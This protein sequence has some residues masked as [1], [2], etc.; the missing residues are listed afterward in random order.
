MQLRVRFTLWFALA[1]LVPIAVAAVVTRYVVARSYRQEHE[2]T[3]LATEQAVRGA[4]EE[5][6]K[7]VEGPIA[8]H[9]LGSKDH[10]VVGGILRELVKNGGELDDAALRR[11]KEIS[12][13]AMRGFSLDVLLVTGPGG[14]VLAA[15]HYRALTGEDGFN[16]VEQRARRSGGAPFYVWEKVMPASKPESVLVVASARFVN[17]GAMRVAVEVGRRVDGSLVEA[18]RRPG[19]IDARI[20]DRDGTVIVPPAEP[21][22]AKLARNGTMRVALPGPDGE[23]VAWIEL[24]VAEEGL[25]DLL[26]QVT[27]VSGV[28][29]AGAL[30]LTVLLGLGVARRMTRDLDR[31]VVGAQSAAKGDLE[32]RVTVS[33]K[34]EVAEVASAF[35]L[36]MEDLRTAKERAVVAERIAAWQEVAR[37]LAH[38]IKN[39][40]TPIQMAMDTLRKTWRKSHPKFGD[41]LEESTATVLEEADRLKRIVSE[42]S[43]FARMP[44]PSY[45]PTDVG[46]IVAS[47]L[48]LY[49]G[50]APVEKRLA[51]GLPAI[52]AD[53]GQLTQVLLN[54]LEN[55]RDAIASRGE[56]EGGR[57]VVSTRRGDAG[58]R[59]EITVEDNGP[60]IPPEVK[61]RMFT[62]YFT[63]KQGKGGTGLGLAIVHRIV[64][65][66]GGRI[67]VGDTAGGGARFAVELPL[68]QGQLLFA[69]RV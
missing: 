19:R 11:F 68:R 56:P 24:A 31:L 7:Q 2:R 58:D 8:A 10:E 62:P 39:P 48:S 14:R 46:E 54:L 9:A 36:M 41:V 27:W 37:R 29:A 60:G 22:W 26:L 16:A 42:F 64:S 51:E 49:Q 63:T 18:V 13:P 44:K 55:A 67:I 30:A 20:V 21:G 33:S 61:D 57:I 59:V 50:A 52:E 40:L 47:A 12:A 17:D 69:S 35:N 5:I 23:P 53:R 45:G 66:H 1:A 38:E 15:P 28:L 65:D 3:R 34:D 4:I 32:H 25:D 43:E 6:E